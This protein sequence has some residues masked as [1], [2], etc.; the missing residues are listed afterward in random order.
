MKLNIYSVRDEASETFGTPF[1]SPSDN[2][3]VR[4]FRMLC[5]DPSSTVHAFP[6][7]FALYCLG[8]YADN[9]G[10]ITPVVPTLIVRGNSFPKEV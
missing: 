5:D 1:F 8:D 3:A 4:S 6:A 2:V 9:T 10:V 7:D